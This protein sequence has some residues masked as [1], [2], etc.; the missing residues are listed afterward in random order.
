MGICQSKGKKKAGANKPDGGNVPAAADPT[1]KGGDATTPSN[2]TSAGE[3]M[4]CEWNAVLRS[5]EARVLFRC[6]FCVEFAACARTVSAWGT[7]SGER[8]GGGWAGPRGAFLA[9]AASWWRVAHAPLVAGC[10]RVW[11]TTCFSDGWGG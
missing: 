9:V 2:T 1:K 11:R 10:Q 4:I 6:L 5:L 7:E 3:K 8:G